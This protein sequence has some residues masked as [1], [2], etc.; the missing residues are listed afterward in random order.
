MSKENGF[1]C[2]DPDHGH[3]TE[4]QAI[5]CY[6]YTY[7]KELREELFNTTADLETAEAQLKEHMEIAVEAEQ[8]YFH[9]KAKQAGLLIGI[10]VMAV[11][12]AACIGY[13]S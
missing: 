8:E 6:G 4:A 5:E 12:W 2:A 3:T 9:I 7:I 11:M 10:A 13:C 1:Y